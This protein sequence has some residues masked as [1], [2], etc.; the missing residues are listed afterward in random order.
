ML[1]LEEPLAGEAAT[2]NEEPGLG[3]KALPR[4]FG[5]YTLL[6]RLAVGGMAELYLA[7]QQSVAGF[8]KLIVVK[9]ILPQL[10]S[11]R[12]FV[13]MLL[14]EARIAAT[15]THP[16][17]A[18]VYDVGVAEGDYFIAMEHVH[19]EDLR[20]VVRQMRHKHVRA[21]PLEHT[22]AMVMGCCKGLAY[23][24]DRRD[25][26]G[27]PL[28]IVHRDISPQNVLVTFTGDVKIVDFGIAKA[29][30]SQDEEDEQ[31][32]GKVPY[33]SPEQAQGLP[34]DARSDL[35]SLGVMLFELSTGKRLFKCANEQETLQRI[36]RGDYPRPRDINPSLSPRLE[37]IILK[38]LK[39]DRDQRYSSARDMQADLEA[40]IRD[41]Q[42]AVSAL[43]LGEWMQNLF[44]DKL[45]QQK[46]MLQEGRQLAEVLAADD[47]Y[48]PA[49]SSTQG[50]SLSGVS[51]VRTKTVSSRASWTVVGLLLL[52]LVGGAVAFW[53][54]PRGAATGPGSIAL[55]SEPTG[56]AI[57]ID[58]NRRSERTPATLGELPLGRY[59]VRLTAE[60][61]APFTDT[62]E[63]TT[64][65]PTG[66]IAGTLERPSAANFGAARLTTAPAGATVLVD[67][68]ATDGLTPLTVA[69]LAPGVVHR[70]AV[71]RDGYQTQHLE[72]TVEAGEVQETHLRLERTPLGDDETLLIVRPTPNDA[73]VVV[74]ENT[75]EGGG[76]YELRLPAE[77]S[78]I[79]VRREGY[80]ESVTEVDLEGGQEMELPV[81]LES[82]PAERRGRRR[83]EAGSE[84]ATAPEPAPAGGPGKLSFDARPWC[85]V[86]IDG[87]RIGQTPIVNRSLSSGRHRVTC[88]NPELGVTRSV[89]VDI[90]PGETTRQRM[91]LE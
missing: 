84:V 65:A 86:A 78:R 35:F 39:V 83:A 85:N 1:P 19:G 58:G 72:I 11:D 15:L 21:F 69:E 60:G 44:D 10:A 88:T 24:H 12:S 45:A 25:L 32:K 87:Q 26:D 75:F 80:R 28:E 47:G 46:Q 62:V 17:I 40:L 90:S 18:Q 37:E 49:A 82:R 34:L 6:R 77:P 91:S 22:L 70:V 27:E 33:M 29:R 4:R 61:F 5:K 56:A 8:E 9:R 13:E 43:S 38:T 36:V 67:G 16:N 68:S 30:S 51:S 59:E 71:T 7:L 41:E 73:L 63:L 14:Q 55:T 54:A 74:G 23:A 53:M 81:H 48:D 52:A 31:L 42:L 20:S 50:L 76:P 66:R 64:N 57:Y 3:E 2:K 79:I 89:T